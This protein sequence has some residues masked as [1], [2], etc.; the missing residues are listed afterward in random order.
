MSN[1]NNTMQTQISNTLYNAIMEAGGKDRSPMLAPSN[2]VQWKSRIKRYIDTKPNHELIHYCLKNPPY[3]F[4]WADKVVLVFKGS[5]E[6]T[7]ERYMETYKNVSQV[8]HDQPNAEAEAV[9]IILTGI[10]NDIYSIVDACPNA[11]EMWKA[12]ERIA[13][14]ANPLALVAQQQ[15]VYHPR[16]HPTHYTQ[17]SSTRT[18]AASRNRRKAIDKEIDK[19]MALISP[20]FKKIYKPTK[21]N[22]RT[23]SN[24]NRANQ[25]NSPRINRG[26]GYDNQRLGNVDGARETVGTTV[27][28]KY[29]IQCYNCK[30]FRH[31]VREYQ[32]PKRAKDAAYHREKMLLYQELE[33]HYIYMAQIQEVSPDT[34]DDS[35]PIFDSE[36][37]QK[38]SNDDNC[39]V[40]AIES[41]HP[42]QSKSIHDIYP[43]EQDE[44]NVIIDSLDMKTNALMYNDLKKFQAELER[45]NDVEYASKINDL[46]QTISEMKK[47]L[48][49]HQETISILSQ[50]KEAQIKLY[51]TCQDKELDK[52]I[53]LE[54][55]VKD[56]GIAISELK[57][58]IEKLEGKSVDT[59]FEKSSVI[60]QPNAFKSQR[61]LILGKPTIFSDS[62]ERKDFSKSNVKSRTK[63]PIAVPVS[64]RETKR[65][66][67]QSVA[68]P[69]RKTVASESTNQKSRQ[70]TRKLY[71]RVSKAYFEVAFQKST[72]YIRDLKGNDLLTGSCG[73]DLYSITL[74]Y[75]TSP[76]PI[77]LMAKAT[78]SQAWLW[79]H[80]LS[81]LNCDTINLLSNNDIVIGLPKLKFVKDHLCSSCEIG[82]SKRKSF[83][84]KTTPSSKRRLQ[85][86]HIDLCGPMRVA[87]INGKKYVLVIVDDYSG[88]A[89]TYFLRSKDETP[90][91]L[92]DFLSL[93][94]EDFMLKDGENLDKMKEK[95]D[96]C[97]F[98]GYSTHS[99]AYR[100]MS[101]PTPFLNVKERGETS[102][103]H[104]DSSNIHTFY[105]H[106]PSEH[107]W[108]KD[109]PLEQ[110]IGN[111]SQSVKTR[112]QL[113][114]DGEM[115]M[116]TLTVSQTEPKNIKEAMADS[117]W[118]E[119]M[120]EELYQ[121]DRLDVWELVDRPLY[122]NVINM[123]WLW[124][125]NVMKKILSFETNLVLWLRDM[126]KRKELISKN[127][128]HPLLGWKLS[129]TIH[130]GLWYPKDTGFE[131]TAFLDSD[132]AGCLDSHKSTSGGIQFLGGD[133]LVSWSSKKHE[134]TSMSLAEAE[135]VSL[136]ACCVQVLWMRTQLTYYGFHF[137]K[138]PMYCD[139][140][141][142]IA[143]SCNP[144]QHSRTKHNDVRY[145]FIKEKVEK[146]IV[147]LLF[148]KTEYQLAD[149]FTKSLLEERF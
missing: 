135:Y 20:S 102:S 44:H 53:A 70:T 89:W 10:D 91:V 15:P 52:V 84:S 142:A 12:I 28:Q 92:I 30:E 26:V 64:T 108:T 96:A 61:P 66:V 74:Q 105:Q 16:N 78:S 120:Q 47:E 55:K 33:A 97:I 68:R 31:V 19:I 131:L 134:C 51:K 62:L 32:K 81:Y 143:I 98:V 149:M 3:K 148:V 99:R 87:S 141:A 146:G 116:F 38:V 43:I 27:V 129:D 144:V 119:S 36:P 14:T 114:S 94:K 124:K 109:H 5:H 117:A 65:T 29:G 2:Y 37:L 11:C 83:Q 115:C 130:I 93:S 59:K 40:F 122:K 56:K 57:K 54:N 136:S 7:T 85:L 71:E 72:C 45:R 69:L 132:H 4:T 6:T 79:H 41:E 101:V 133:K 123:K 25:D 112:R 50:A 139:S 58:L 39:N 60:R 121:F 147:E 110:V 106:H 49:A 63:L 80:H 100:I 125:T 88:Y 46:N 24:T 42:E 118:I 95:G 140:K 18:Q 73:T 126:I 82:K 107:R 8:I 9:Q 22:L 76:I 113:E 17:N 104:V 23:S 48:S 127:H 111:P 1:T 77:C 103:R 34:V 75:I 21:N 13:R 145:H 35:V 90:E 138:I 128:L 137:D 67:K 86:L